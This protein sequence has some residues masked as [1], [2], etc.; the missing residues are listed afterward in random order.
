MLI[1]MEFIHSV[2]REMVKL[3]KEV[4]SDE[5]LEYVNYNNDSM[6]ILLFNTVA[7]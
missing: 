3:V 2:N 6:L 7:V 4:V 1:S 5:K